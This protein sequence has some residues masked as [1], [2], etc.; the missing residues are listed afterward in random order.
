M[1]EVPQLFS[2]IEDFM[3]FH[4]ALIRPSRQEGSLSSSGGSTTSFNYCLYEGLAC[5]AS[6]HPCWDP[7]KS[8]LPPLNSNHAY[9]PL[10]VACGEW[11]VQDGTCDVVLGPCRY[12]R[13]AML[14]CV[15]GSCWFPLSVARRYKAHM[16]GSNQW[17]R[18][19]TIGC[20]S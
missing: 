20:A 8:L 11:H 15:L 14:P 18:R 2:T 10:R 5:R 12:M 1:Q 17:Y 4:I 13:S 9:S 19:L 3:W 16:Q 7:R 6:L